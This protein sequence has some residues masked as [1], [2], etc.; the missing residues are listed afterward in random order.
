MRAPTTLESKHRAATDTRSHV[1]VVDDDDSVRE[2]LQTLFE[3]WGYRPEVYA[4]AEEFLAYFRQSAPGCLILDVGLPALNGLE[5]Q[6]MMGNGQSGLPVIFI[7]G[8]GDIPMTVQAM[9]GGAIEFLTKPFR[10]EV[11]LAAVNS[12]IELSR[13]HLGELLELNALRKRRESLSRREQEVMALVT[14]GQLNKQVAAALGISEITVKAHRG[15]AMRKMKAKSLAELVTMAGRL[16]GVS[17]GK[18]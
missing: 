13:A 17:P 14:R 4:S 1:Y 7:T 11:L 5:L 10:P 8:N 3:E 18:G 9:K 2:S 16:R 15:R 12:A 6:Q